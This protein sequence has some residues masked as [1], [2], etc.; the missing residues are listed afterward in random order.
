MYACMCVC[1]HVR[2]CACAYV[3]VSAQVRLRVQSSCVTRYPWCSSFIVCAI[4]SR[5][6]SR[7]VQLCVRSTLAPLS[8]LL[9]FVSVGSLPLCVSLTSRSVSVGSLPLCV[10][11][12]SH[13]TGV[14]SDHNLRLTGQGNAGENNGPPGHLYVRLQVGVFWRLLPSPTRLCVRCFTSLPSS[15]TS[16][17]FHARST[18][19]VASH[20]T[21]HRDSNDVHVEVPVNIADA[22]LGGSVRVPTLDG[23]HVEVKVPE[24][25][26]GCTH[27]P[28]AMMHSG[29][30]SEHA[31]TQ[32]HAP[33]SN[34]RHTTRRQ[35]S[36]P[37]EGD[38]VLEL[39]SDRKPVHP[40]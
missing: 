17:C 31:H 29:E 16:P 26:R 13:S 5:V 7:L 8:R 21:F 22:S 3:C 1:A 19:Q 10:S 40:L 11:L 6:V 37:R 24:G 34:D 14:Q 2:M 36:P 33:L 9:H 28:G 38:Q 20:P 35:T 23:K 15:L 25:M 39:E 12:T 30:V 27:R 18:A 4:H 32:L